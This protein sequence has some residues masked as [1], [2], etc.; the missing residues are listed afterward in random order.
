M[1]RRSIALALALLLVLGSGCGKQ[2][3]PTQPAAIVTDNARPDPVLESRASRG[4][5]AA[6]VIGSTRSGALFA[7][8][9][10]DHWN[11]DLVLYAHGFTR[12]DD[13]IHLPPIDNLRDQLLAQG[14]AVAYS[15]FA[16]NGLAI[17]DGIRQTAR[18]EDLFEE[19]LGRPR[20]VFLIGSS[21]GGCIAVALAE[22]HPERYAGV[23]TVSGLIG[24]TRG[25]VDY[26]AHVRVLFD[27][28]YPGVLQGDLFHVPPGLN[29]NQH[30]LGPAV[31]AMSAHPQGA[32]IISQIAQ[33]PVPFASGPE[34]VGSIAT[35]LSLHFFEVGDL[36]SR[37]GGE[38]FFDNA[39]VAYTGALPA[40]VLADVNARVA[41]FTS[42]SRV[43]EL[44]DDYYE[45]TGRLRIPMLAISN[46]RDP[47]V[48]H[49]NETRYAA[50][51]ASRGHSAL[52]VQRSFAR[53]GHT[54]VFTP[55]EITQAFAELVARAAQRGQH[56]DDDDHD[57]D[58]DRAVAARDAAVL[59]AR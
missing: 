52:L 9:R 16:E 13:T 44:L 17:R 48:G 35:A 6:Q 51:V 57:G 41:R 49:F 1:K 39:R 5:D 50:L 15:S 24:G 8:Y 37:T 36:M 55:A 21:M 20:R 45:P 7:M 32:G 31:Q 19:K 28:Y 54:E 11:R 40:P 42:T 23:L 38:S 27:L 3:L 30:V 29:L 4:R 25:L 14:F 26:I 2:L 53:Y 47:Q 46:D 33:S 58:D 18:L 43:Q 59:V 56:H 12:P 22:R 10:P 34:L